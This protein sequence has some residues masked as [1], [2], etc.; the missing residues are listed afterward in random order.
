MPMRADI[1][2][3]LIVELDRVERRTSM[4]VRQNEARV[5]ATRCH[6]ND[7]AIQLAKDSD[8]PDRPI[9]ENGSFLP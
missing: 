3:S 7:T 2:R 5:I 4:L 8:E 6:L 9:R 1:L